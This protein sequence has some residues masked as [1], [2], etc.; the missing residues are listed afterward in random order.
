MRDRTVYADF[1]RRGGSFRIVATH[2]SCSDQRTGDVDDA[3]KD[4]KDRVRECCRKRRF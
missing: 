4:I 1:G 3:T 2:T